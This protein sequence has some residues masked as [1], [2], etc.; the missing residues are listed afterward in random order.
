M[1][2]NKI[3]IFYTPI[4][5]I[6]DL[7][8]RIV[9][10]II[11]NNPNDE[12]TIVK[13]TGYEG[14][15][16][17]ISNINSE[18][19]RCK[20]C[21][22]K[23]D[24]L[25]KNSNHKNLK[26][27][28]Y[29]ETKNY[30]QINLS[31]VEELKHLVYQGVNIGRGVHSA[32]ITILKDHSYDISENIDLINKI[33]FTS[34][35]TIDY[36]NSCSKKEIKR[37]YVFNGRVSHFNAVV[38]FS[39]LFNINYSTFEA[40]SI[41]NKYIEISDN[42]IHNKKVFSDSVKKHWEN[43]R[44]NN[45]F[46]NGKSF[47]E[48]N[49]NSTHSVDYITPNFTKYQKAGLIPSNFKKDRTIIFFGSSRNEYESVEGWHNDFMSGD[50]EQIVIEICSRLPEMNFFYREHPNMKFQNNTQTR[51]IKKFKEIKN[52]SL[53]DSH[54]K[55]SSYELL[56]NAGKVIVFGSTI[57]V[58]ANYLGKPT[59][60]L[61]PSLYEGLNITYKPKDFDELKYL[62][63]KKDLKPLPCLDSIKYGYFELTKGKSISSESFNLNLEVN[64]IDRILIFINKIWILFFK[65]FSK[66]YKIKN[67]ISDP[68]IRKQL[69]KILK[70]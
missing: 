1:N 4:I 66:K 6:V 67:I 32:A 65:F 3:L 25:T 57:G 34:K 55:V 27:E 9:N 30:A 20:L 42:I 11:S 37:I 31:S 17:C 58:E 38:E 23:L 16:N 43:D 48:K 64:L 8:T 51:N 13:C 63:E 12:V 29:T 47:F 54:S 2:K 52:L 19:Y 41:S 70:F 44:S 69:I 60:C 36:L 33:T 35:R 22:S 46:E 7:Y 40:T 39:K 61:G 59:I 50:D 24:S 53:I 68:R 28:N 18:Y 49:I 14:L 56:K 15:K 45:K 21:K 10:D 62:L 5:E 26:I